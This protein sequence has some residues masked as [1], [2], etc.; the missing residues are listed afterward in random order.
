MRD[1]E[2]CLGEDHHKI[3]GWITNEHKNP[4]SEKRFERARLVA[5]L[6]HRTKTL[7]LDL[8]ETRG[9]GVMAIRLRHQATAS[10]NKPG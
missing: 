10:S 3:I 7:L 2:L 9:N 1:L 6:S 8:S 4:L 5:Q